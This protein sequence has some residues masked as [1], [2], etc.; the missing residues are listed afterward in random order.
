[1]PDHYS[2][3]CLL[4]KIMNIWPSWLVSIGLLRGSKYARYCL[5]KTEHTQRKLLCKI[6]C[7]LHNRKSHVTCHE[8]KPQ[9]RLNA[10]PSWRVLFEPLTA[11][12]SNYAGLG[13][14]NELWPE[15]L[16]WFFTNKEMGNIICI[17][18][19]L[20]KRSVNHESRY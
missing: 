7:K 9:P 15:I 14:E 20:L 3:N 1:M 10:G 16:I 18:S 4:I 17:F 12:V 11:R 6:C 2:W 5:A 13:C 8:P 19:I